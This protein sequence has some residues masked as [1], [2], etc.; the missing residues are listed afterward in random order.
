MLREKIIS[1]CLKY[2]HKKA[3]VDDKVQ[4]TYGK[5]LELIKIN[6]KYEKFK[7]GNVGI[8]TDHCIEGVVSEVVCLFWN[9]VFI[10]I[11]SE[12]PEQRISKMLEFSNVSSIIIA[13]D[14]ISLIEKLKKKFYDINFFRIKL[15]TENESQPSTENTTN[16]ALDGSGYTDDKEMY[17]L[18][19]SG[20][21]GAPK[22]VV[23]RCSS[24]NHFAEQYI[25]N[26]GIKSEDNLTLF[27]TLGHDASIIDI[28]SSLISGATLYLLDLKKVNNFFKINEWI[29]KNRISIW[30]SVPTV[31]RTALRYNNNHFHY[32]PKVI[33]LGG[34]EV[35]VSDFEKIKKH[36]Q[37]SKFY[38]LYGQTEHSYT[39]GLFIE[40][41][42]DV[43]CVG[44]PING[45]KLALDLKKNKIQEIIV[46][47]PYLFSY[48]KGGKQKK[49]Q[50]K[51]FFRTGDMVVKTEN[52]WKFQGRKGRQIKINGNRVDLAGIESIIEA[53]FNDIDFAVL[54][55]KSNKFNTSVLV[56]V[57]HGGNHTL[58]EINNELNKFL[59]PYE[60]LKDLINFP[61]EF[62]KTI[63][64]K[65]DL[66]ELSNRL[67]T[68]EN[69]DG[70][71][72][73][74]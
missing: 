62:P 47:S 21:T 69:L 7:Y 23:Q 20:S 25:Q 64:G 41:E 58:I 49:S 33:V 70:M 1:N 27:S 65:R 68:L 51:N 13:T 10:P 60:L 59:A 72:C 35:L 12:L 45:V 52:G 14:K 54:E 73:R 61:E 29:E 15:D 4:I 18:Y 3:F 16:I 63:T 39:S 37:N 5:L 8:I 71:F 26:V 34:E 17:H 19:T 38:V 2:S 57:F 50:Q 67:L 11:D 40:N 9:K 6:L 48:Y 56:G 42:Q 24:V 74:N 46:N 43:G 32:S 53:R 31:L 55:T 36:F 22:A 66:R 44:E 30:H 28:Y